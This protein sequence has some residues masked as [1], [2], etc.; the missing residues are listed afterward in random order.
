MEFLTE[1]VVSCPYC[2]EAI[3][4]LID[5][6]EAGHQYIEDCQ[7]CCKPIIFNVAL[8]SL[9]NLSVS[10]RDENEA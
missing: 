9:G 1:Q 5:H 2:G 10:V 3:E 6:Q 8:G 4:V 7:V